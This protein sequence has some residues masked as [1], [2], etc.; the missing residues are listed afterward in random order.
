[1]NQPPGHALPLEVK[2]PHQ[3]VLLCSFHH[4]FFGLILPNGPDHRR[5]KRSV[6]RPPPDLATII[7]GPDSNRTKTHVKR[8]NDTRLVGI[9]YKN[10]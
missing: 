10:I 5:L 6:S 7:P 9:K 3:L 2:L 4:H 1:M 8:F